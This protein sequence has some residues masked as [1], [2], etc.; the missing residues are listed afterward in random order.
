MRGADN[1]GLV[2]ASGTTRLALASIQC[3]KGDWD[4]N[5]ET[6]RHVMQEAARVGCKFVVFPEMSLTGSV[7]P[8]LDPDHLLS[9]DSPQVAAIA[10]LT[11]TCLLSAV[12]GIAEATVEGPYIT[13]IYASQGRIMGCQRKRHL[14]DGEEAF[15]RS[16]RTELFQYGSLRFGIAICA[17]G[18][19]DPPFDVPVSDGA[20]LVFYC[21]APGLHGR[22]KD[23]GSWR[24]GLS[25][26]E[27]EGLEN[28]RR[29]ARRT[30]AWIA[31]ATQAGSTVDEDFPGL[32]AL[33]SPS[34]AVIKRSK[35]WEAETII[36]DVPLGFEVDPI[37]RASRVLILDESGKALLVRFSDRFGHHWWG[38]PGGGLE[39]GEDHRQAVTR[40][41]E[42]ELS[43]SD[44][45]VGQ[46]IGWRVHTL[47]FNEHPWITQHEEWF[48]CRTEAFGVDPE[49][50]ASLLIEGVTAVTWWSAD[51][52]DQEGVVTAPR[53]L[54]SLI[55]DVNGG[56]I[57]GADTDLGI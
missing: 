17:E 13:Q 31:M 3:S 35:N 1:K 55:R 32:S 37:R 28:V 22:R 20:E 48:L 53:R 29:H 41:L 40:E 27:S 15:L 7:D 46:K 38:T 42:E 6:H 8:S 47:S 57:P 16:D 23:E 52:L 5:L 49:H 18:R 54:A 56:L 30:G 39:S 44:L 36:V 43:R 33:V 2:A 11:Q 51:D 12:F 50:V 26:W 10:D 25:W 24:Q 19:E 45:V 4:A 21:A 14:G 9:I 34:G